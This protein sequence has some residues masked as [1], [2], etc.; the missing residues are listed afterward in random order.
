MRYILILSI[1]LAS[2]L[3]PTP[4]NA[5]PT[6]QATKLVWDDYT[7]PGAGGFYLY[8]Q[9]EIV[10]MQ[11]YSDS[12]R[13]DIGKPD[14]EQIVVIDFL[15][16]AAGDL[17]FKLTAYD[18]A[19]DPSNRKESQFSN[20]DCGFFGLQ[21]PQNLKRESYRLHWDKLHV[22]DLNLGDA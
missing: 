20:Q 2:Y 8:W 10:P 22:G 21:T 19:P 3:I 12:Q 14:P 9:R 6:Q 17:C 18:K 7:D 15:P 11:E 16:Q 4:V 5:L 13:I 1:V